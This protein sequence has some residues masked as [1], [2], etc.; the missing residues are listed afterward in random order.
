M[1]ALHVK[2][3]FPGR[4]RRVPFGEGVADFDAAF[5][6]LARQRWSGPLML[7]M[8]H[9]DAPDSV[10]RCVAAR[11]FIAESLGRAG[12]AIDN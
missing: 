2:D 5:T 7:E 11:T 10:D 12:I 1:V 8:W 6:E 3:V 9:D 4:P